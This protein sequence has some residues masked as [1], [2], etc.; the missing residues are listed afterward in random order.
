MKD[1]SAR[2]GFSEF[3]YFD[4]PT[5]GTRAYR[6]KRKSYLPPCQ[7]PVHPNWKARFVFDRITFTTNVE[8]ATEEEAKKIAL[9]NL[10]YTFYPEHNL[11]ALGKINAFSL[12]R[13]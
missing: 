4:L 5:N 6:D 13:I 10:K 2:V 11:K 3:E 12:I 8:A 9:K 7:I 1:L